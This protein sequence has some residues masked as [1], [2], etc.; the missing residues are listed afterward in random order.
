MMPSL[1]PITP[2]DHDAVVAVNERFVHL[3]AAMDHRRLAEL[4]AASDRADVVDV[5]GE[6]AGFVITFAAGAAYDGT[7]FAWFAERYRDY[8]YLD[9]IVI[10]QPFQR[11]GLGTFVYDALE[12]AC[13]RPVLALEV[14][15]DP[16]NEPSLAFHR[17][18][19]YVEVGL[20]GT[21]DH[22]VVLMTKTLGEQSRP[23]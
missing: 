3:T 7:H 14:N 19:G 9:R 12:S 4:V 1:R 23:L 17:A 8:C 21:E 10:D 11:R 16:P 22:R 2:E 15:I 6:F 18:R 20:E 13:A 5:D